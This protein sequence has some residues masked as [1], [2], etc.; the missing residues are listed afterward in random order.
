MPAP[1]TATELIVVHGAL[2]VVTGVDSVDEEVD[3][4]VG[5]G[6]EVVLAAAQHPVGGHL[7]ERAEEDLGGGGRR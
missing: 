1:S 5:F 4:R 6:G 3:D 2:L 7:V